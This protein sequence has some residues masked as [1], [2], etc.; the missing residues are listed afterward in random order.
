MSA[1]P[2]DMPPFQWQP[3]EGLRHATR[4]QLTYPNTPFTALCG[5][6]VTPTENNF[7]ALGGLWLEP[8]CWDCDAVWRRHEGIPGPIPAIEA[9]P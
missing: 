4:D 9:K 1:L 6:E 8:T 2:T 5:A 7:V 3:A